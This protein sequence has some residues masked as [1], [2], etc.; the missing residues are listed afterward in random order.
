MSFEFVGS[1]PYWGPAGL[2]SFMAL[3]A[4]IV[5]APWRQLID[6]SER[7][8]LLLLS[9]F[10]LGVF[11]LLEVKIVGAVSIHP[12]L[13]MSLVMVF[14]LEIGIVAGS[15]ALL[16]TTFLQG[17]DLISLVMPWAFNVVLAGFSAHWVLKIITRL[18]TS[19]LFIYMLGG[20]F[21]GAMITVQ[22]MA[23]S[24]WLYI[25]ILGPEPLL[26]IASD[27]YYLSLLMMFPEG[28]INGAIITMMTV[29]KP[30]LVRSFDDQRYLDG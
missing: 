28:F 5:K 17:R 10:V 23:A 11:W 19:N 18:P 7:Q 13:M 25:A 3:M 29:F 24:Q 14:G 26:V 27:Y 2:M 4:L 12:L 6:R 1:W 21:F 8:H 9:I 30:G 16:L 22:V 20:G 15:L